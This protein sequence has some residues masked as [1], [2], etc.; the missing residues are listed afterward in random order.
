MAAL[1]PI[2]VQVHLAAKTRLNVDRM[3]RYRKRTMAR[4][5]HSITLPPESYT[6]PWG[7][8]AKV[9]E[10]RDQVARWADAQGLDRA[11]V[12]WSI[13]ENSDQTLTLSWWVE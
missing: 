1:A 9:D 8:R 7:D 13:Q 6:D 11:Q 3:R 5:P 2:Q 4:P 10:F 12:S